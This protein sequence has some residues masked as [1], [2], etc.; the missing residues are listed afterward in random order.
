MSDVCKTVKKISGDVRREQIVQ[1]A[2]TIIGTRGMSSL[3]TASIAK[4]VGMSEANLYRHLKNKD[5]IYFTCFEYV[6]GRIWE[7]MDAASTFSTSSIKNLRHLYSL[8]IALM[9]RNRG[10]S[11]FIFSEDLHVHK[12][13][14]QKFIQM[15]S[16]FSKKLVLIIKDGQ[17]QKLIRGDLEPRS[18][19]MIFI[20]MVQVVTFRWSLSGFTFPIARE[21]MELWKN[22]EKCIGYSEK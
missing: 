8:Q 17:R 7:N 21:G 9:E 20:G 16:D 13:L 1:A 5:E 12:K 18:T 2:L 22:F 15:V 10:L 3:T 14:R 19:A 4:E 6:R 11:R